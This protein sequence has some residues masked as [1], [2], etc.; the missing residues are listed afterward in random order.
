MSDEILK[1]LKKLSDEYEQ[2]LQDLRFKIREI[3]SIPKAKALVGRC[4]KLSSSTQPGFF[5]SKH[6][7]IVYKRVVGTDCESVLVD[8]F[9]IE[10]SG[11]VEIEYSQRGYVDHYVSK[12]YIEIT[13]KQ[14]WAAY[15]KMVKIIAV[16]GKKRG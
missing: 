3:D 9:Q 5:P 2:Q 15:A 11:K 6:K 7:S 4:F 14:Y 16:R 10:H 13:D 1:N 12:Y 8:S